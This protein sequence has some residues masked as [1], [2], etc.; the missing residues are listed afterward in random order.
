WDPSIEALTHFPDL[1]KRMSENLDWT[2]DLGDA[3][4]EQQADVLDAVQRMRRTAY[5]SGKLETT[6]EQKVVVEK[7]ANT[8]VIKIEQAD[9]Q[10]VYV[11]QYAPQAVYGPPAYPTTYYPAM[12]A[13]PPGYVAT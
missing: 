9:P 8:Q 12:Y 2:K 10:V 11:P 3:F 6:K 7:E 13:Y 4:L 5:D 1:L